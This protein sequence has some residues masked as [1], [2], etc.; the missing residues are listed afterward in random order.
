LV[1]VPEPVSPPAA[2]ESGAE[3][4][5]VRTAIHRYLAYPD[6]ARRRGEEGRVLL[7]MTVA[8]DGTLERV[9]ATP[10]GASDR[11]VTAALSAARRAAPFDASARG[12]FRIPVVFRLTPAGGSGI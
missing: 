6:S 1:A 8:A 5:A 3:W 4:D 10:D 2:I 12:N 7:M 11:L 9:N